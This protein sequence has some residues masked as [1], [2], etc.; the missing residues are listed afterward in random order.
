MKHFIETDRGLINVN[1]IRMIEKT[2]WGKQKML[3]I[4]FK[5]SA[6]QDHRTTVMENSKGYKELL[7]LSIKEN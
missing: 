6:F 2:K 3:R 7:N 5:S 1:E 4:Y